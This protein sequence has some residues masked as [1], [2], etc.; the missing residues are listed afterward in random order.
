M[1]K[2]KSGNFRGMNSPVPN[3]PGENNSRWK[4][5][6]HKRH[7]G[8]ILI[9]KGIISKSS[10]GA[11]YVLKHRL[12][13]EEHLKRPLL[14]T[15]IVHHKNGNRSDNRIENLEIMTQARHAKI[16]YKVDSKTNR[17]IKK[18]G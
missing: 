12:V 17:F 3:K 13:M 15:E 16:H 6:V 10:K 2:N 7:D 5:G 1:K 11:R 4:G 18:H 8:Y 9:R 14:K